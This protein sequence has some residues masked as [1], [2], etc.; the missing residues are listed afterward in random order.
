M[1][2][3]P[4]HIEKVMRMLFVE[5]WTC[6]AFFALVTMGSSAAAIVALFLNHNHKSNFRHPL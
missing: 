2:N 3:N 6:R 4:L 1:V 5:L